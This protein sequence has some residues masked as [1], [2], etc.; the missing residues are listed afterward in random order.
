M[1]GFQPLV[2]IAGMLEQVGGRR[3]EIHRLNLGPPATVITFTDSFA[4]AKT[5]TFAI[6]AGQIVRTI[7]GGA[8]GD[9]LI[10]AGDDIRLRPGGNLN[11]SGNMNLSVGRSII[12]YYTGATWYELNRST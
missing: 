9:L 11:L 4:Y 1:T 7:T 12:L 3:T 6:G 5:V 10:L 2:A 8:V